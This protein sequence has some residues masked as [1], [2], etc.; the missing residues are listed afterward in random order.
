[1]K[2]LWNIGWGVVSDCNM[3]CEFCYSEFRRN[4]R[5]DLKFQDW[6]NFIESNNERIGTIN[7]G[8][9]ENC[10]SKDWFALIEHIHNKHPHIKQAMTTNGFISEIICK[11]LQLHHIW[12][13]AID[14]IDISLDFS[15]S[16][17][18]NKL[19]GQPNAYKWVMNTLQLCK[20]AEKP[21]T[22]VCLGSKVNGTIENLRGIFKIAKDY[23][24]IVRMNLYRPSEG[25][26]EKSK[27]F[28]LEPNEFI[29]LIY[30]ISREYKVL[31]IS[32]PLFSNLLTDHTEADPSGIDSLR[33][34]PDGSVTPSTYL[35]DEEFV[36]GS[37]LEEN[38]LEN[39]ENTNVLSRITYEEIP[40]ECQDCHVVD[41]CKGGVYDRRYLWYNT[42]K[43]KDPYCLYEKGKIE[44]QKIS[45]YDKPFQSVHYG[46]L[47]TIF[48]AP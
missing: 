30:N 46:Y 14:E 41:T 12:K 45:I 43:R 2:K 4:K 21:T 34:L 37:I 44:L 18:H 25:I 32:D 28:I 35:I 20:E 36:V 38:I 47:P 33:V 17:R 39:I 29:E 26:N 1:M 27:K 3:K 8:T 13:E 22:I 16:E 48:F 9:G 40:E 5:Q 42:L 10:I 6:I 15:D 19:R 7:Y 23:N 24:A 11:D 31:A